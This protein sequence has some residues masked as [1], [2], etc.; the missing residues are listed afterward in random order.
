MSYQE[1]WD[2][3]DKLNK[4]LIDRLHMYG[5]IEPPGI[6]GRPYNGGAKHGYEYPLS[7]ANYLRLL[8]MQ[9]GEHKYEDP[10][11]IWQDTARKNGWKLRQGA[12]PAYIEVYRKDEKGDYHAGLT[13]FVKIVVSK[14]CNYLYF[15]LLTRHR[16]S[17]TDDGKSSKAEIL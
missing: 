1:I 16:I 9:D 10:R 2:S 7:R 13:L 8:V 11:W 5:N 14:T 3:R 17:G 15:H 4:K 12:R 6:Y